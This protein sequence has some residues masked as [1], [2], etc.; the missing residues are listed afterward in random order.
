MT[1]ASDSVSARRPA[2]WAVV[3]AFGLLYITWGTTYLAIRIGVETLPPAVFSGGRLA[4]AGLIMLAYLRLRGL[5]LAVPRADWFW[6]VFPAALFFVSG[7]GLLTAGEVYVASGVAS[8][9]AATTP[10]WMA[11]FERLWPHGERLNARGWFGIVG[12]LAGVVVLVGPKWGDGAEQTSTF[13]ALLIL[14]SAVSWGFGSFIARNRHVRAPHLVVTGYQMFIGGGSLFLVGLMLGEGKELTAENL[15]PRAVGAFFYLLVVGSI[16]GFTAFNW[17]L[18]NVSSAMAG[19]YAYVNPVVAIVVGWLI[20]SEPITAGVVA[21][22]TIIL[23]G[24]ALVRSGHQGKASSRT[25]PTRPDVLPSGK[26]PARPEPVS[27]RSD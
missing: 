19:T 4:L 18:R 10:L 25:S 15:T 27:C 21:G 5:P 8:I 20:N 17:L 12:G 13:G 2:L 7:N 6:L 22:I 16:I 23:A 24:V 1:D 11:L 3:L 14:G 26:M 9:L